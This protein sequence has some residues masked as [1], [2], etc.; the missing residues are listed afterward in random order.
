MSSS[1][2]IPEEA[3][4]EPSEG[5]GDK[6][7]GRNMPMMMRMTTTTT[8]KTTT[9]PF[10]PLPPTPQVLP[11]STIASL[12]H[13]EL[14]HNPEFMKHV[15]LVSSL[16]ELLNLQK[17]MLSNFCSSQHIELSGPKPVHF[18]GVVLPHSFKH[19]HVISR[20][21]KRPNKLLPSILWMWEDCKTD[22]LVGMSSSKMSRPPMQHAVCHEDSSMLSEAEWKVICQSATVIIH[23]NLDPLTPAA[24]AGAHQ[25]HK[26][27]EYEADMTLGLVLQDEVTWKQHDTTAT[28]VDSHTSSPSNLEGFQTTSDSDFKGHPPPPNAPSTKTA[29]H[30][31]CL[32]PVLHKRSTPTWSTGTD[33]RERPDEDTFTQPQPTNS[34]VLVASTMD[35]GSDADPQAAKEDI[36]RAIATVGKSE[37]LS[38]EGIQDVIANSYVSGGW[39]VNQAKS[40]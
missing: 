38:K 40:K 39:S 2:S 13:D 19:I 16:Q 20:K 1:M 25:S 8:T 31:P 10:P 29:P 17:T 23:S 30:K 14:W 27:M 35:D 28:P 24:Q 36:I 33:N 18:T 22:P 3:Y 32:K 34:S 4:E 6:L 12:T 21:A 9:A 26:K 5:P 7:K 37:Q 11:I 15:N